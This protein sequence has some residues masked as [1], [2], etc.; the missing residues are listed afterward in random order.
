M[1][2][3]RSG[4]CVGRI[5][6][7]GPLENSFQAASGVQA[8]VGGLAGPP[9]GEDGPS[10]R[11]LG[12]VS[13]HHPPYPRLRSG[14]GPAGR[15][16]PGRNGKART[17][18]SSV[19]WG[20]RDPVSPSAPTASRICCWCSQ[21]GVLPPAVEPVLQGFFPPKENMSPSASEVEQLDQDPGTEPTGGGRQ[22]P[23]PTR[24]RSR[25]ARDCVAESSARRGDRERGRTGKPA[26]SVRDR[27][28]HPSCR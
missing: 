25:R 20:Q 3:P 10:Q 23:S 9:A 17:K 24:V 7:R 22:W 19:G 18:M 16:C 15:P 4:Y 8:T 1:G 27:L 11:T 21:R 28:N 5:P 14:L 12:P 2:C 13:R 26:P 6:G